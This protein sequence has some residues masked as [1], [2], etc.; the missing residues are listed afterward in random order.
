MTHRVSLQ[1]RVLA[2]LGPRAYGLRTRLHR[3]RCTAGDNWKLLRWFPWDHLLDPYGEVDLSGAWERAWMARYLA[4]SYRG[5]GAVVELGSWLGATSLAITRGLEANR[6]ATAQGRRVHVFDRFTYQDAGHLVPGTVLAPGYREGASF[7]S[8]YDERTAGVAHRLVIH[9]GDV[10]RA[11]W[12]ATEPI[13]VLFNDLSKT[14]STWRAVRSTFYGSLVASSVVIEQ[15]WGHAC[16][17]WLH[18]AHHRLRPY[19]EPIGQLPES[20]AVAFRVHRPLP[21][22]LLGDDSLADYPPQEVEAAFAWAESLV[23]ERTRPNVR[24]AKIM[25]QALHGDLEVG[26]EALLEAF[27]DGWLTGEAATIAGPEL[28]RRRREAAGR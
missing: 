3:L 16:T 24:G 2:S 22:E 6:R 13:E 7:R 27:T 11:S 28:L 23:D 15:D 20:G 17:P 18:L 21:P 25:L 14:W 12:P 8:T 26:V 9:E 5:V 19:L 4:R 1:E 10:E